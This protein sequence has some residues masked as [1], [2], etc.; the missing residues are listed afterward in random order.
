MSSLPT[1]RAAM[2]RR[3]FVMIAIAVAFGTMAVSQTSA[4]VDPFVGM[5]H[6]L[7]PA[8]TFRLISDVDLI[9]GAA[10]VCCQNYGPGT[11]PEVTMVCGLAI[12]DTTG[13]SILNCQSTIPNRGFACCGSVEE[14]GNVQNTGLSCPPPRG[15]DAAAAGESA[16]SLSAIVAVAAVVVGLTASS[17]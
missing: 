13:P 5:M 7:C 8:G 15:G 3:F 14:D 9:A 6:S 4:A 12:T 11:N 10:Q 2:K 17:L 16:V 1:S